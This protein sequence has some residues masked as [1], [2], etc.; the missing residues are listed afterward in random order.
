MVTVPYMYR[1]RYHYTYIPP[2]QYYHGTV[3]VPTTHLGYGAVPGTL[4]GVPINRTCMY[5]YT[6]PYMYHTVRLFQVTYSTRVLFKDTRGGADADGYGATV[7]YSIVLYD[8]A[9]I[10]TTVYEYTCRNYTSIY[11]V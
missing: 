4:T 5:V 1:Y 9:L 11:I 2:L 7:P 3:L 8:S 6:V 10:Y